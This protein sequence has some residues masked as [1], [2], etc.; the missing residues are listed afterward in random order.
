M[1]YFEYQ[2]N[3]IKKLLSSS[4]ELLDLD[5]FQILSLNLL[6]GQEKLL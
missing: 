4:H 2:E 5:G 6:L 1:K 3:A